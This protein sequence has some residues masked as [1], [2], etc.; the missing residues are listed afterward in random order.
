MKKPADRIALLLQLDDELLKGGVVLSEWCAFLIRES[1]EAFA[2]GAY[3]SSLLTTMSAIE[4]FLRSESHIGRKKR[5]VDLI[6][7]SGLELELI[8]TLNDLRLYRNRWVHIE[9][10]WDD[11]E[12]LT[13]PEAMEQELASK[14][15]VGVRALRRVLYSNQWV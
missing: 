4:T 1:D 15:L 9:D 3:L 8:N 6:E 7:H 12:L 5:L 13:S 11:D 10:P 14:A 2:A